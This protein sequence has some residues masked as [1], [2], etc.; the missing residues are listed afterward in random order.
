MH[1]AAIECRGGLYEMGRQYGEARA[2]ELTRAL[3][4]FFGLFSHFPHPADRQGLV[5]AARRLLE[6]AAAFDP[7]AVGFIRGQAEGARAD[8]REVFC[9]HCFLEIM[10]N[11]ANLSSMCTSLALTGPATKDGGTIAGQNIDWFT[12]SPVDLLRLLH[13]DGSRAFAVCLFGVPYYFMTSAGI[14]NCAN[15]TFGPGMP[16]AQVPLTVYLSKAMRAPGLGE[17][18]S[19]IRSAAN[20]LGYYHLADASGNALGIESVPGAQVELRPR[21]GVLVHAN[22]YESEQFRP[23]DQGLAYMPDSPLRSQRMTRL[24]ADHH[25][26]LGIEEVME[27]LRDHDGLP[28]SICRHPDPNVPPVLATESRASIIMLPGKGVLWISFGPPCENAYQ[29]HLLM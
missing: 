6:P 5:R 22:H 28:Y 3:E 11:Y 7:D 21:N 18:I 1:H 19:V 20:G 27:M 24:I 10:F 12:C 26:R 14:C 23:L 4:D 2:D 15:L 16:G 29:E 25:G 17:A 8:F 13:A 9:L